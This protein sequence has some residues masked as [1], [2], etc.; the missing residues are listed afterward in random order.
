MRRRSFAPA[1]CLALGAA[2]TA[3]D[4]GPSDT[5][6][7]TG[8]ACDTGTGT[9]PP[10]EPGQLLG[11]PRL[12]RRALLTLEGRL[13][14]I[15]EY[16]QIV[17]APDDAAREAILQGVIEDALA[18]TSFYREMLRFGHDYFHNTQYVK[19]GSNEIY[20]VGDL[21]AHLYPCAPGTLHAGALGVLNGYP[22]FGDPP[23]L[24]DDPAAP[25]AA[26]E[27]WWAAGTS[28]DVIGRAAN[29]NAEHN[30]IDCGKTSV[31][32]YDNTFSDDPND[33]GCGCGPNLV[34]CN[35]VSSYDTLHHNRNDDERAQRRQ[36]WD[37]PAR[38][39]AHLAWHD[40]PLSD[41]V[42]ANYSVA[43]LHLQAMYLRMGRRN[44]ANKA[45]DQSSFWQPATWNTPADPEHDVKDPLAWREFVVE[46]LNPDL[47]AL[48]QGGA[49]SGSG[50]RTYTF[51]PRVN[52]GE[53]D[54]VGA[55]GVLT[56]MGTVSAFARERVRAAR[57]LE[58]FAC[59]KFV[60]PPADVQFNPYERDPATEGVCQHCHAIIDPAAIHFKRWDFEG[61]SN[62]P[63][64][65][66]IGIWRWQD[67]VYGEPWERWL[68]TFLPDT[69][70]T[71][72]T[73]AEI[74]Q[75]AD[76]RF[77]DFLPPDQKLFG[78]VSDGTVGPLGFAKL[79]VKS[80]EL[81]RCLVQRLYQR[82]LGRAIDAG[83]EQALL[84]DLTAQFV[85]DGR[86]LRPF[87][88]VLLQSEQFRRG[89]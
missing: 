62:A 22:Q 76:V 32:L 83:T 60:P 3:C 37:E 67:G 11:Y 14:T 78:L 80:G 15:E 57:W 23:A 61:Y 1:L 59:K 29:T 28:V 50:D 40:R 68:N 17:N 72:V 4:Q 10:P 33:P 74:D 81:D 77:L 70:M 42:L 24:C 69:R 13:P 79:L 18:G 53:P 30:G 56:M 34:Y 44:P 21:Q 54:G 27:P 66:G 89:L 51:D 63:M 36:A 45:L 7:T 31:S 20:W 5:E 39:F 9:S 84:G 64:M 86:E 16:E 35:L 75:N 19:G 6:S 12:L 52:A 82:F 8:G 58:T 88:R 48:S 85:A 47:L 71:P 43:P 38:F 26:V 2:V 49:A 73:Q 87:V 25:I 41:L 55:A 65:G 46:T